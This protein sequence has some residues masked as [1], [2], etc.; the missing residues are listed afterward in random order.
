MAWT[1]HCPRGNKDQVIRLSKSSRERQ[2][3]RAVDPDQD[4]QYDPTNEGKRT[5][6]EREEGH[7]E[8]RQLPGD[9]CAWTEKR[10]VQE[11]GF[12]EGNHSERRRV[13]QTPA[14]VTEGA[15]GGKPAF[16]T[17]EAE[18]SRPSC[19]ESNEALWACTPAITVQSAAAAEVQGD[20]ERKSRS[21][22]QI[23]TETTQLAL[24]EK[25]W[26]RRQEHR[27]HWLPGK[28]GL[29][30][31]SAKNAFRLIWN[32]CTAVGRRLGHL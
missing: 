27:A 6:L 2:Y 16:Q 31:G 32:S 24:A 5:Q 29:R 25:L 9:P 1:G 19:Y 17:Q 10:R 13:H 23:R 20:A 3:V 15:L 8:E 4:D 11:E 26:T 12:S 22:H 18:S 28:F 30:I 7:R 14:Q 21:T